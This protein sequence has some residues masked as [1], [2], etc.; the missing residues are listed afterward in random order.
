MAPQ[1]TTLADFT[2]DPSISRKE[3]RIRTLAAG[4]D[5]DSEAW[6]TF[7]MN[8]WDG[9]APS[10]EVRATTDPVVLE[11][12]R[13]TITEHVTVDRSD[14]SDGPPHAKRAYKAKRSLLNAI[15][16]QLE[17]LEFPDPADWP[18]DEA[19]AEFVYEIDVPDWRSAGF[20]R[21]SWEYVWNEC[22]ADDVRFL[23]DAL[24][25]QFGTP[26]T[27]PPADDAL[28]AFL[29]YKTTE[30]TVDDVFSV[31]RRGKG[32]R[33]NVVVNNLQ[34]TLS[35]LDPVIGAMLACWTTQVKTNKGDKEN[36]GWYDYPDRYLNIRSDNPLD[37]C[38][39]TNTTAH[40]LGHA[41]HHLYQFQTDGTDV[42]NRGV[43]PDNWEWNIK[44]P[45][46]TETSTAQDAFYATVRQEWEK[47]RDGE[48]EPVREY[49]CKNAAEVVADAFACWICDPDHL[50][51]LQPRMH[52]LI[53]SHFAPHQRNTDGLREQ[54]FDYWEIEY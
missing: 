19:L 53:E 37:H 3:R 38:H 45:D 47:L 17:K 49:Q 44:T 52:Q 10:R 16:A 43:D 36:D 9:C 42:D 30:V 11:Q 51:E 7:M 1:T 12:F 54:L 2:S 29:F 14:L 20:H 15:D 33:Y 32:A 28:Q 50:A 21:Q 35:R 39:R 31:S 27:R 48:I 8:L 5:G 22:S 4:P 26:G 13:N 24:R 34:R 6:E 25:L 46:H 40:E 41:L 18:I 23:R